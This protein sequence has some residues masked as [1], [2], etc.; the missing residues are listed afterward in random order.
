MGG[1]L[2]WP[3]LGGGQGLL[4]KAPVSQGCSN[5]CPRAPALNPE[6]VFSQSEPKEMDKE[7]SFFSSTWVSML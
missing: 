1:H 7:S 5:L 6:D 4:R 3:G 2:A